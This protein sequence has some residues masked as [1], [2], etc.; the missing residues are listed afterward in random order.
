MRSN[1][2]PLA[3]HAEEAAK[4]QSLLPQNVSHKTQAAEPGESVEARITNLHARLKITPDEETAWNGVAQAMRENA[5]NMEK[6]V[7]EKRAQTP[8]DM[9]AVDDLMTYQKLP[10]PMSR[11]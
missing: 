1:V 3:A 9:T 10:R 11:D 8:K 6:L 2:S 5:A 7:A 4:A